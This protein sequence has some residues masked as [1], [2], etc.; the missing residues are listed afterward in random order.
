MS[1]RAIRQKKDKDVSS[2]VFNSKLKRPS[3]AIMIILI[4]FVFLLVQSMSWAQEKEIF[5]VGFSHQSF[6]ELNENDAMAA[7][8][9]W[10]LAF[11]KERN[12]PAEPRSTI[13]RQPSE[14][15]KALKSKSVDVVNI[16]AV[17]YGYVFD[18]VSKDILITGNIS[19]TIT[20]EYILLVNVNSGVKTLSDLKGKTLGILSSVRASLSP[21]WIDTLLLQNGLPRADR[22]FER[23]DSSSKLNKLLI[24][25]FFGKLDACVVTRKGFDVM[26]ELNPQTGVRLH[27][28]AS[29][30]AIIPGILCFR[31]D[32]DSM[33]IQKFLVE[34]PKWHLSPTGKQS[35][36]IF[37][38]DS[39]EI[40]P[41]ER[42][43]ST[44]KLIR[45]HQRLMA[46]DTA[47]KSVAESPGKKG[48]ESL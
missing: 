47:Q 4:A 15:M 2:P 41:F 27:E 37:Q 32:W 18:E 46:P 10:T 20:E 19:G 26:V 34:I 39:L 25:L 8:K 38:T 1:K 31:K 12:I 43:E 45:E 9:A 42:M 24:P 13:F 28:L 7:I 29:S 30:A 6:G 48:K 3:K 16:T 35:L 21:A 23:I 5:R 40:L 22:F 33:L 44:L 11:I 14:I 36:R 17:E